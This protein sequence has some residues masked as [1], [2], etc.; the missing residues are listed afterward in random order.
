ML[1]KFGSDTICID[2]TH[3]TNMYNFYLITVLVVDEYGEGLPVGWMISNREDSVALI[4]FF[5]SIK[6]VCGNITP[7]WFMSD[8]A[9]QYFNAWRGENKTSKL[10]C[11]WHIHRAWCKALHDH[12]PDKQDQSDVYH[13]LCILLQEQNLEPCC[14]HF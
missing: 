12:I 6:I 9:E 5:K 1:N 8:D 14:K 11:V 13:L 7:K 4:E 3:G 2:A 10:L